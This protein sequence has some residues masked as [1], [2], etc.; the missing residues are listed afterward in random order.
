V[1]GDRAE[2]RW[3]VFV[4][5]GDVPQNLVRDGVTRCVSLR[6]DADHDRPRL[7]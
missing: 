4:G 3:L 6:E 5:I 2:L 7:Q 1:I